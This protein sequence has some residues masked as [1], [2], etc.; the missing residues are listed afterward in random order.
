MGRFL[1]QKEVIQEKESYSTFLHPLSSVFQKQ[2]T[3][4]SLKMAVL[5]FSQALIRVAISAC[6]VL[7]GTNSCEVQR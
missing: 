3:D 5:L 1:E 4:L 7:L 2:I 6:V